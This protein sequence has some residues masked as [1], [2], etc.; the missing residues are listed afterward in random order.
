MEKDDVAM[1]PFNE[2]KGDGSSS[3]PP[4]SVATTPSDPPLPSAFTTSHPPMEM[5]RDLAE[6]S[7]NEWADFLAANSVR[8]RMAGPPVGCPDTDS[9]FSHPLEEVGRL[10][11]AVLLHHHGVAVAPLLR[12]IRAAEEDAIED[13]APFFKAVQRCKWSL[14]QE[15]QKSD[16]SH[17]EVCQP[18][19]EKCR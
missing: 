1:D 12:R 9:L 16:Q 4:A 17:K 6:N 8:K 18:V 10:L 11:L 19:M 15:R 13:L 7:T 14:F 2:E 3:G 5:F